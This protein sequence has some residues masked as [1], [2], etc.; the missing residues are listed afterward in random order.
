MLRYQGAQGYVSHAEM[1][2]G[3]GTIMLGDPGEQYRNPCRSGTLSGTV[4]VTVRDVLATY[5]RALTAGSADRRA[6]N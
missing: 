4:H 3:D 1:R 2:L 6:A 5:E